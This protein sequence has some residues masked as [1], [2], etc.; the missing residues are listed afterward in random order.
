MK[1]NWWETVTDVTEKDVISLVVL[2]NS[3]IT[4]HGGDVK[5]Y[6]KYKH[7]NFLSHR[8]YGDTVKLYR[9]L[10][11]LNLK[12]REYL[13]VQF[14]YYKKEKKHPYCRPFPS[15]KNLTSPAALTRWQQWLIDTK[16]QEMPSVTLST[17]DFEQYEENYLKELISSWKLPDEVSLFKDIILARNFPLDFLQKRATFQ[18]LIAA[19]YY[20]ST[21]SVNDYKELF[22]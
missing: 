17:E 7:K 8:H 5:H 15:L 21:Y 2:Y 9:L 20:E 18:G 13:T 4:H 6:I 3:F 10:T 12:S 11:K 16:K 14:E 19:R 1:T 22:I